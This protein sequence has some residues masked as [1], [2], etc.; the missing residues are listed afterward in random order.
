[1]AR[2]TATKAPRPRAA[3]KAQ[4]T[5]AGG[6][7]AAKGAGGRRQRRQGWQAEKSA[8]TRNAILEAAIQCFIELG[9]AR[10]TTALIAEY[11]GVSRGAMMHHFPSRAEVL[12]ATI[13]HLHQKRL[14]EFRELMGG[15]DDPAELMDRKR[16]EESVRRA[17]T[18]VNQPTS[19]AFQEVLMASRTDPEL[20]AVLEP[21]EREYEKQFMETVK[22]VFP[23][24]QDLDNLETAN[25]LVHFLLTGMMMAQMQ[26]RKQART[27]RILEHLAD[28]LEEIYTRAHERNERAL[29]AAGSGEEEKAVA[30]GAAAPAGAST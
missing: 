20:R 14:A 9:Y 5:R 12:K 16:I 8:M 11:A 26:H 7:A 1:M 19:I 22:A 6:R 3:G 29:A 28:T 15:I 13:E 2:Q 4:P 30:E 21:L 23:H 17:W 27:R 18:Y 25:D 10:T 24:W